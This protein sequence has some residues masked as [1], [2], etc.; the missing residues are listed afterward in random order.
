M[1]VVVEDAGDVMGLCDVHASLFDP[2]GILTVVAI[3]ELAVGDAITPPG[4]DVPG[5]AD[6]LLVVRAVE[7]EVLIGSTVLEGDLEGLA[8]VGG[9]LLESDDVGIGVLLDGF[10][11]HGHVIGADGIIIID[12]GDVLTASG[13]KQGLPFEADATVA[14]VV[15]NEVLDGAWRGDLR[16]DV[17]DQGMALADAFPAGGGEDGE[18]RGAF[19]DGWCLG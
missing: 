13:I 2:R 14:V 8:V 7:L 5:A 15:E 3:K 9:E 18:E 4:A 10:E 11:Q 12:E 1:V 6:E 17:F 16:G 19:H